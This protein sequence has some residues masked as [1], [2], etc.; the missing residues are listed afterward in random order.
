MI[1]I[2]NQN[3]LKKESQQVKENGDEIKRKLEA[4]LGAMLAERVSIE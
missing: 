4:I 3:N 2:S 1:N